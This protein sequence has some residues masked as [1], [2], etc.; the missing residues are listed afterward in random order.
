[1]ESLN[2]RQKPLVHDDTLSFRSPGVDSGLPAT[3]HVADR[4]SAATQASGNIADFDFSQ[5]QKTYIIVPDG[6]RMRVVM[7]PRLNLLT[8]GRLP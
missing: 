2:L 5:F 8:P 7:L 1:M 3:E 4:F 6:P